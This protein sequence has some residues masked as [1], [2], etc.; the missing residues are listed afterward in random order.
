MRKMTYTDK[1]SYDSTP[2]CKTRSSHKA[3]DSISVSTEIATPSKS[4]KSE[5]SDFSVSR[6]TGSN[7]EFGEARG[8]GG[9][10]HSA[11]FHTDSFTI[12]I[13]PQQKLLMSHAQ[14]SRPPLTATLV[15]ANTSLVAGI[16]SSVAG[17][18]WPKTL[19]DTRPL[20]AVVRRQP[21]AQGIQRQGFWCTARVYLFTFP[22]MHNLAPYGGTLKPRSCCAPS[23]QV[24]THAEKNPGVYLSGREKIGPQMPGAYRSGSL[25]LPEFGAQNSFPPSFGPTLMARGSF[26]AVHLA[27]ARPFDFVPT[28][29][30][31]SPI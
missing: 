3:F 26:G 27:A 31:K 9:A 17:N 22:P 15:A 18:T 6:G 5:N 20:G 8:G 16:T 30:Q 12:I 24:P 7:R 13:F 10:S 19:P 23:R 28:C 14:D 2:P 29:D 4:T 1:A 11:R 25:Y 21:R